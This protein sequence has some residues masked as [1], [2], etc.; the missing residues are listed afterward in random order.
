MASLDNLLAVTDGLRACA[1]RVGA[2]VVPG[3]DLTDPHPPSFLWPDMPT[4]LNGVIALVEHVRPRVVYLGER[5]WQSDDA[6]KMLAVLARLEEAIRSVLKN[7]TYSE[8]DLDTLRALRQQATETRVSLEASTRHVGEVH[9]VHVLV[10]VDGVAHEATFTASW[11]SG[12]A[13]LV[14]LNNALE[15]LVGGERTGFVMNPDLYDWE[16]RETAAQIRR[17]Q[18]LSEL[19]ETLPLQLAQDIEF[20]KIPAQANRWQYAQAVIRTQRPEL[21][22]LTQSE[23]GRLRTSVAEAAHTVLREKIQPEQIMAVREILPQ[24]ARELSE[25]RQWA[26]ATDK[27]GRRRAAKALLEARHPLVASQLVDELLALSVASPIKA[28]QHEEL[29]L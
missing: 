8:I 7:D 16:Q 19:E 4:T 15:D 12:P 29:L 14:A 17:E 6:L 3:S 11:A 26:A 22:P 1:L 27:P 20:Q 23:R 18:W 2:F 28:P 25:T 5:I 21:E 10:L 13:T 9:E 24:L